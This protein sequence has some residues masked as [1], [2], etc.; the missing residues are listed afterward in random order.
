VHDSVLRCVRTPIKDTFLRSMY[1]HPLILRHSEVVS[2]SFTGSN[3]ILNLRHS[4][5]PR[6][7]DMITREPEPVISKNSWLSQ[8]IVCTFHTLFLLA[9]LF[10]TYKMNMLYRPRKLRCHNPINVHSHHISWLQFAPP[11]N[12]MRS[13]DLFAQR[14][15]SSTFRP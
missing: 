8:R 9:W 10:S 1:I 4:L 14:H 6:I 11:F 12:I 3:K 15:A 13:E 2:C 5:D 7:Y